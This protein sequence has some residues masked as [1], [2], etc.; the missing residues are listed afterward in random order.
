MPKITKGRRSV[1]KNI[2]AIERSRK[3]EYFGGPLFNE[4]KIT[5]EKVKSTVR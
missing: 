2:H 5:A 3:H 4:P 1:H